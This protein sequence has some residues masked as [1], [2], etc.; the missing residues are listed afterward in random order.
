MNEEYFDMFMA[1]GECHGQYYVAARRY[2]ELY[3]N[4]ARHPSAPVIL[5][6]AQI[7]FETGSVLVNK[8]DTGNREART[9]G[10]PRQFYVLS[11]RILNR[12]FGSSLES[13]ICLTQL[14]IGYC[15]RLHAFHYTRVQHL[16]PEDY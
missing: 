1:L 6:A 3:P 5:R 10:I 13:T 8:H 12:V 15:K 2:A 14:Y 16:R 4:R 11:S 9:C 7:L